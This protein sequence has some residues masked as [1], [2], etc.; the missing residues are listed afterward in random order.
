VI[1]IHETPHVPDPPHEG[2]TEGGDSSEEEG[3]P[4]PVTTD[5]VQSYLDLFLTLVVYI[6]LFVLNILYIFIFS[7]PVISR[8]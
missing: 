1:A 5:E 2:C 8:L 4:G 6:T 7:F 3:A